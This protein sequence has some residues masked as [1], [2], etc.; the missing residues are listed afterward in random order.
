MTVAIS[1][2]ILHLNGTPV[3]AVRIKGSADSWSFGRFTPTS[4]F[5][6]FAP[7]FGRWSLLMHAD[8]GEQLSVAASEELRQVE[9]EI[10]ALRAKLFFPEQNEWKRLAQLNIDGQLIE[11]KIVEPAR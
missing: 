10:D 5:S 6:K 4:A 3:G 1:S 9:Y 2:A 7:L 11:W 8:L